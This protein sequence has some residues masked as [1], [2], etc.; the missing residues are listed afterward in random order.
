MFLVKHNGIIHLVPVGRVEKLLHFSVAP[1]A[2][3]KVSSV[4]TLHFPHG[5][6]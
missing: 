6:E 4:A 2:V 3:A 1:P 5:G